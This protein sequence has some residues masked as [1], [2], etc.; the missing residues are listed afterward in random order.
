MPWRPI[1]K[2]KLLVFVCSFSALDWAEW[3]TSRLASLTVGKGTL[4]PLDGKIDESHGWPV[5]VEDSI[6]TT[7]DWKP[8]AGSSGP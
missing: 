4:F 7:E 2:W 1:G 8:I 3:L 6:F 5:R